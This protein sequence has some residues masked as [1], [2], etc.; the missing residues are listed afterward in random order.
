MLQLSQNLE[1]CAKAGDELPDIVLQAMNNAWDKKTSGA[2]PFPYWRPYSL[3][4]PGRQNFDQGASY[5][6]I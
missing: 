3:D 6:A 2:N 1:A 4:I 5:S